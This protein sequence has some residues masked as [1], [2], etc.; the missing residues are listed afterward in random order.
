MNN[1]NNDAAYEDGANENG[2]TYEDGT[3]ETYKDGAN[4]NNP[5]TPATKTP[6]VNYE[7]NRTMDDNAEY[8]TT[9]EAPRTEIKYSTTEETAIMDVIANGI[10]ASTTEVNS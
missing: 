8:G 2:A 5:P 9:A 4:N 7:P 1:D 6:P 10:S 3:N